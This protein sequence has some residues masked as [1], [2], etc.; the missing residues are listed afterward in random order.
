MS[1]NG[2]DKETS[3][4]DVWLTIIALSMAAFC[5]IGLPLGRDHLLQGAVNSFEV[6]SGNM[7][8]TIK[9]GDQV[10]MTP[11][12]D[13]DAPEP[14]D[15][16]ALTFPQEQAREYLSNKPPRS[17]NCLASHHLDAQPPPVFIERV[18]A[19]GGESVEIR[20]NQVYIDGRKVEQEFVARE[21]TG[22]HL[23][24]TRIRAREILDGR[25]YP[26]Q[27][28]GMAPEFG[29]VDVPEGHFFVV[30]DSRDNSAD[31]RCW[32]FVPAENVLGRIEMVLVSTGED[33]VRWSR[34]GTDLE[35]KAV[36][37]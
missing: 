20:D 15:I 3:G 9:V 35:P 18:I 28:T 8:P 33:G 30:G 4:R 10:T 6:T 11:Y 32:G 13:D 16:I 7:L 34:I 19:T 14:G 22:M 23:Y 5:F 17:Q 21:E 25:S 2:G 37:E 26:I 24:P 1:E 12:D 31:S 36:A 27:Y 29:P